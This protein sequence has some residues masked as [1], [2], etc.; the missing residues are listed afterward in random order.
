VAE[1]GEARRQRLEPGSVHVPTGAVG[2]QDG[3]AIA[4]PG[5][6]ARIDD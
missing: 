6:D 4:G 5:L 3:Q 1:P 2:Q